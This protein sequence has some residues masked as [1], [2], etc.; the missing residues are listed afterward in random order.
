M[1]SYWLFINHAIFGALF[2][3]HIKFYLATTTILLGFTLISIFGIFFIRHVSGLDFYLPVPTHFIY[4]ILY[5]LFLW[6]LVCYV[7]MHYNVNV[8]EF[9]LGTFPFIMDYIKHEHLQSY[10]T[11]PVFL[12]YFFRTFKLTMFQHK[13]F[14]TL[15][16]YFEIFSIFQHLSEIL[17]S[18]YKSADVHIVKMLILA[19]NK[20][21]AFIM[22]QFGCQFPPLY[23]CILFTWRLPRG[24]LQLYF[25]ARV[26]IN[27]DD[28]S[29]NGN[30]ELGVWYRKGEICTA[31]GINNNE[32]IYIGIHREVPTQE[33]VPQSG[34]FGGNTSIG[35]TFIVHFW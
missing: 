3:C 32:E 29:P 6:S 35:G 5:V 23:F 30:D 15:F 12:W 27:A 4:L 13:H 14:G 2:Y 26:L 10:S 28:Y 25:K 11:C 17:F 20:C 21:L 1:L 22:S 19:N 18:S 33:S 16:F 34:S 24:W 7:P 9:H 31:T 8:D